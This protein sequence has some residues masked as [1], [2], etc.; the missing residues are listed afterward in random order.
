MAGG[1]ARGSTGVDAAPINIFVRWFQA[2]STNMNAEAQKKALAT[3]DVG[4]DEDGSAVAKATPAQG[5]VRRVEYGA[6]MAE[7]GFL[8][9]SRDQKDSPK[10]WQ[11]RLD[12]LRLARGQSDFRLPP[13]KPSQS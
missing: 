2:I 8:A 7:I 6:E 9:R 11:Q 10:E 12:K 1:G 4:D 13:P 5:D 3:T